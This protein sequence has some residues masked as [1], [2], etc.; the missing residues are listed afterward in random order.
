M[1]SSPWL[2]TKSTDN[3]VLYLSTTGSVT[4]GIVNENEASILPVLTINSN[5]LVNGGEGT[6]SNPYI[7]F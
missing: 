1:K 7:L 4:K 2:I 3:N 6:L 5:T